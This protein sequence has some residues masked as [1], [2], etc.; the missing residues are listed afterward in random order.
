MLGQSMPCSPHTTAPDTRPL[1]GRASLIGDVD[2]LLRDGQSVLLIGPEGS[3][4]SAIIDVL[5]RPGL[6]VVDPFAAIT[7]PRACALRRALN[8]GAVVLAA[9]RSTERRD[10]GHVG[11]IF[12]RFRMVRV[13]ALS[14]R[15]IARILQRTLARGETAVPVGRKWIAEAVDVSAGLPGRAVALAAASAARWQERRAMVSPRFALVI[16]RQDEIVHSL[17]VATRGARPGESSS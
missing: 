17:Q 4:K 6:V 1:I 13:R 9:A 16:A 15:D 2:A 3:G 12:W 5:R 10:M 11:R 14:G 7:S 8:R